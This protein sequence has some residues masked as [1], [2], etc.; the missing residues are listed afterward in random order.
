MMNWKG[1]GRKTVMAEVKVMIPNLCEK[2]E[3]NI[4][5]TQDSLCLGRVSNQV[6][7]KYKKKA[8]PLEETLR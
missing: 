6:H 4:G 7:L 3:E 8:S 1:D 5:R 2:A